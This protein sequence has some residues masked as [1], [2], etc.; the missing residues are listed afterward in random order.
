VLIEKPVLVVSVS[1]AFTSGAIPFDDWSREPFFWFTA[2]L[3]QAFAS[4]LVDWISDPGGPGFTAA[5]IGLFV[6]IPITAIL[7]L[8]RVAP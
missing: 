8:C 1:P 6:A 4:V 5:L 3:V 2:C 7:H